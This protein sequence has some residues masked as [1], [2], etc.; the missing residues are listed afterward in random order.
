MAEMHSRQ[1]KYSAGERRG[2]T[3]QQQLDCL[4]LSL[5]VLEV[6]SWQSSRLGYL[7]VSFTFFCHA[8]MS[9]L[10]E[11]GLKA[12]TGPKHTHTH[13]DRQTRID[14]HIDANRHRQPEGGSEGRGVRCSLKHKWP[15]R[16]RSSGEKELV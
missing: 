12:F 16:R 2:S 3:Q 11:S 10:P 15:A 14:K 13:T 1:W 9:A 7:F 8:L 4:N 5:D 6:S